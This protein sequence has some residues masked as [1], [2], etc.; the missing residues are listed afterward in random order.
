[1]QRLTQ[2][3]AEVRKSNVRPEGLKIARMLVFGIHVILA[4]LSIV[5][6]PLLWFIHR[7]TADAWFGV[8]PGVIWLSLITAAIS[9]LA[10][11]ER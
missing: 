10:N 3:L 7:A 1:M 9:D 6:G 11:T 8:A 2:E 4:V 5:A